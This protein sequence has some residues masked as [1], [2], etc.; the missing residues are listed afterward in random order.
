L[1]PITGARNAADLMAAI[2]KA[3]ATPNQHAIPVNDVA[4]SVSAGLAEGV[5]NCA[6]E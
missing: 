1:P 6:W 2:T 5:W 4:S 3:V